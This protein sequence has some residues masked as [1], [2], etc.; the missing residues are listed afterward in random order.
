MEADLAESLKIKGEKILSS[1][2]ISYNL[3]IG[4]RAPPPSPLRN[5]AS[6]E[7]KRM[8]RGGKMV[9]EKLFPLMSTVVS[10]D[11]AQHG[12]CLM[13]LKCW[14]RWISRSSKLFRK[15]IKVLK[16]VQNN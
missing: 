7:G 14:P 6:I 12:N 4:L 9:F 5:S 16:S 8:K 10:D 3:G 11:V 2:V 1:H 15:L 13:I